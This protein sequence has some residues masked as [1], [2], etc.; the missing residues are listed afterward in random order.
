MSNEIYYK[1]FTGTVNFCNVDKILYGKVTNAP[2]GTH[3]S[4]HGNTIKEII[5]DFHEA[6]DLHLLPDEVGSDVGHVE[7]VA[8]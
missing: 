3:I 7:R 1:G 6:I 2:K 5:S 8:V 4:Y